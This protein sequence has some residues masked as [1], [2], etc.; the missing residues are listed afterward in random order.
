MTMIGDGI[1]GLG[2]LVCYSTE[3]ALVACLVSR[4][5]S[6]GF[7]MDVLLWASSVLAGWILTFGCEK[8]EISS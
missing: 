2:L 1:F 4:V 6:N 8:M 5:L 7:C 3:V